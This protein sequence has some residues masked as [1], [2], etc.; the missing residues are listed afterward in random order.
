M[1]QSQSEKVVAGLPPRLRKY[2]VDQNYDSYTARDHA[3]W[4]YCMRLNYNHLCDYAHPSYANGLRNS[5]I[6]IEKIPSIED[7]NRSLAKMGWS[8]VCV[9]GFIPPKVFMELQAMGILAIAADIRTHAHTAYTPSPDIIHEAAGH[10]PIIDDP[11][12]A[13]FLKE[14]GRTGM[15]A[16]SSNE[17]RGFYHAVRK[18]SMLKE[19]PTAS[20][21]QIQEAEKALI[22]YAAG[23]GPASEAGKLTRMHWWTTEYGLFGDAEKPLIFGAGLLSSPG[24]SVSCYDES[25][26]KVPLTVDCVE[27]PYDITREQ[28]QLFVTPDF[29]RL[30]AVLREFAAGMA[31][32]RGGN[33]ALE[34]A[35]AAEEVTTC[36]LDTGLQ[37]TGTV[38]FFTRDKNGDAEV[39]FFR[40]GP[41]MVALQDQCLETIP[42][43]T[44]LL[45]ILGDSDQVRI[46]P[47]CGMDRQFTF[48]SDRVTVQGSVQQTLEVE[49]EVLGYLL[50]D[51][52]V[53]D[54]FKEEVF[55]GIANA[56]TA[57]YGLAA[58]LDAWETAYG[59]PVDIFG[60]E[61]SRQTDDP[62]Q[63]RLMAL[64][65]EIRR[66]RE[67]SDFS[68]LC[69]FV[70]ESFSLIH[71]SYPE[72]WLPVLELVELLSLAETGEGLADRIIET[73][74]THPHH[75]DFERG[76]RLLASAQP[77]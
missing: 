66:R 44:D 33:A 62:H 17:D 45:I 18:L 69:E 27:V 59:E 5:G 61:K 56:V 15:M 48:E 52:T 65:T 40:S 36:L 63:E 24:E 58:D 21:S 25:V 46:Q 32:R 14:F 1:N 50:R 41:S 42:T 74:T 43:G 20:E 54:V 47:D 57:V 13:A 7:M 77:V 9:R 37:L 31:F 29:N 73:M 70:A 26:R 76:L 64:Y 10:A 51:V 6:G 28:P 4:R 35:V 19:D 2:V 34:T 3:V 11:D 67:S 39:V 55:V 75:V 60:Y 12:Y 8:A 49:G 38:D 30:R 53:N 68:D 23:M 22:D 71:E 72:E 16:V